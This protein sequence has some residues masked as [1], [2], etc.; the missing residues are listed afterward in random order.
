MTN[1]T[2]E[3]PVPVTQAYLIAYQIWLDMRDRWL[4]YAATDDELRTARDALH[5]ADQAM[6]TTNEI[7]DQQNKK[8]GDKTMQTK[9]IWIDSKKAK[10]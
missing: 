4:D 9:L 2:S 1:E 10:I 5:A 3:T 6:K 7:L 8:E